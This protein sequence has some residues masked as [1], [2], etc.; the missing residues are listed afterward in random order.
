L[1]QPPLTQ[2][3]EP[4]KET[5]RPAARANEPKSPEGFTEKRETHTYPP[6]RQ[7]GLT[8]LSFESEQDGFPLT[9]TNSAV[10][11]ASSSS[12]TH[13]SKL[14]L[15]AVQQMHSWASSYA[16]AERKHRNSRGPFFFLFFFFFSSSSS[17]SSSSSLCAHSMLQTLVC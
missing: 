6:A 2:A 10:S 1:N 9:M 12:P 7:L 4:P 16:Q 14:L 15:A 11:G 3:D 13:E 5:K 8:P 17:S